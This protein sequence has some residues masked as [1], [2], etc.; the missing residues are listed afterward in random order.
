MMD[1][2]MLLF[3]FPHVVNHIAKLSKDL[4]SES[5]IARQTYLS[6]AMRQY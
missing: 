2:A 3:T 6:I 1:L 5:V 4:N